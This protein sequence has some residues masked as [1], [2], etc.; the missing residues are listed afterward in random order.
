MAIVLGLAPALRRATIQ[1]RSSSPVRFSTVGGTPLMRV[2]QS[3]RNASCW[4]YFVW[5]SGPALVS[6]RTYAVP[7]SSS[8][9]STAGSTSSGAVAKPMPLAHPSGQRCALASTSAWNFKAARRS[10]KVSDCQG[11]PRR[12]PSTNCTL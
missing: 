8:G 5:V 7:N 6:R 11:A 3:V 9:C 12:P 1:S 4:T 10:A 2:S